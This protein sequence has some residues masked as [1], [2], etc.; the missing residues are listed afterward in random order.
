MVDLS[1]ASSE[2]MSVYSTLSLSFASSEHVSVYSTLSIPFTVQRRLGQSHCS[3]L[4]KR[5]H[6]KSTNAYG[7]YKHFLVK[8]SILCL[9]LTNNY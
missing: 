2:H 7:V 4:S 9:L 8:V 6:M 5:L 3:Q 1:F